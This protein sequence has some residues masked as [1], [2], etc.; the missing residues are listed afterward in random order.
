[1]I[2]KGV[3]KDIWEKILVGH[4]IFFFGNFWGSS[5]VGLFNSLV[6]NH[7]QLY[8]LPFPLYQ[9]PLNGEDFDSFDKS[10]HL[11]I[12]RESSPVFFN[13][14]LDKNPNSSLNK[15]GQSRDQWIEI[16]KDDF[17]AYLDLF[18]ES[19]PFT[20]KNYLLAVTA[21][22]NL[23]LGRRPET[24]KFCF[25]VHD[26][27]RAVELKKL[28]PGCRIIGM[29]RHPLNTYKSYCRRCVNVLADERRDKKQNNHLEYFLPCDTPLFKD[30]FDLIADFDGQVGCVVLEELHA[31]PRDSMR[32]IAE[33]MGID[34]DESLLQTTAGGELWCGS[35]YTR[36]S[37]FSKDLHRVVDS[38]Y[39]GLSDA[40]ALL[41]TT[42]HYQ[43]YLGYTMRSNVRL[44]ERIISR[45]LAKRYYLERIKLFFSGIRK[46]GLVGAMGRHLLSTTRDLY[47]YSRIRLGSENHVIYGLEARDRKM[48]YSKIKILNPLTRGSIEA[49]QRL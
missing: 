23:A 45:L 32:N 46:N 21:A 44:A 19:V 3:L 40:L 39:V 2:D 7:P 35:H 11:R 48:D 26:L 1:M 5:G 14:S 49:E 33:Y 6:D 15:L 28:V 20:Y 4:E 27:R 29:A 16:D 10:E 17:N 25:S 37:G 22:Y 18:L 41:R 36:V 12:L 47:H 9:T 42:L 34:F 8:T 30:F 24:A 13:T 38:K 43:R 31:N